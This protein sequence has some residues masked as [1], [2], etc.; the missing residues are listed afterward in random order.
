MGDYGIDGS[1]AAGGRL[2]HDPYSLRA[3]IV[4][5]AG[6]A[7][8]KLRGSSVNAI[9]PG[10]D[11]P[12]PTQVGGTSYHHANPFADAGE[13]S[14][15]AQ[16]LGQVG[17]S[18]LPSGVSV[19]A[20]PVL[21]RR[22]IRQAL[23]DQTGS[24]VLDQRYRNPRA[25]QEALYQ[26]TVEFLQANPDIHLGDSLTD[27][28][29]ARIT[30]PILWYEQR[31][32]DGQPT[33]TPQLILPPG[34][35]AEWT[36]QAGGVIQGDSDFLSGDQVTNTGTLLAS[37]TL[38]IDAGS[39]LNERRVGA[40]STGP[41]GQ[42]A[43]QAGGLVSAGDLAIFTRGDLV[44][45][46]G[47][48]TARGDLTLSAG[49]A[50]L[51]APQ[52]VTGHSLVAGRTSA[53]ATD[54]TTN[55]GALVAAGGDLT[56]L[57]GGA[58]SVLG[59]TV[60]AGRDALLA[61]R[62]PVTIASVLDSVSTTTFV[63]PDGLFS[64]SRTLVNQT[65]QTNVPSLVAAGGDLAIVSSSDIAVKASHLVAG[66]NATVIGGQDISVVGTAIVAGQQ[67][68]LGA[69]RDLNI[70]PSLDRTVLTYAHSV[71][72]VGIGGNATDN[73][74][75]VW[76][77]YHS[78]SSLQARDT[79][80]AASL[81][82][83]GSGVLLAAGRDATLT[84]ADLVSG[85]DLAIRA[86]RDLSLL[87]QGQLEHD[88]AV[89]RQSFAG[90][91]ASVSQNVTSAINDLQDAGRIFN[92]G[93]GGSTYQA[94]GVVSG[95]LK[96]VDEVLQLIHPTVSAS[97]TL[98]ASSSKSRSDQLVETQHPS[99]IQAAGVSAWRRGATCTCRAPRSRLAA[100]SISTPGATS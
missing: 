55:A 73:G 7:H 29:K 19:L 32:I 52:P 90:I 92:S 80:T 81:V 79:T 31:T 35:L 34:R 24:T 11:A 43:L 59:S 4:G 21:E 37:G 33:L 83:G 12:N 41:L 46:G 10:F 1:R 18:A 84:A 39:F 63:R 82:V 69:G 77:G 30:R 42:T 54:T 20:D 98:G 27:A 95:T 66:G 48:L 72:G 38:L 15:P 57:A 78:K 44:D 6:V 5:G 89:R 99:T 97:L 40:V 60:T 88:I 2:R 9:L 8:A 91:R 17:G 74:A 67:V 65:S 71:S 3:N 22:L 70:A 14:G 68:T 51:I 50:V 26:G 47:T 100:G 94:I 58:L 86:G 45:R 13:A 25:Q 28:Q 56:I 75:S 93:Y 23:L 96:T 64:S 87:S 49:G 85:G 61:A 36:H 16:I 53:V 76:A 62:G